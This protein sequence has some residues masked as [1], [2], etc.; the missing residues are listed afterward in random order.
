MLVHFSTCSCQGRPKDKNT[1][2]DTWWFLFD[3]FICTRLSSVS[4][5]SHNQILAESFFSPFLLKLHWMFLDAYGAVGKWWHI[6]DVP[7]QRT[8]FYKHISNWLASGLWIGRS[9]FYLS[10]TTCQAN[11]AQTTKILLLCLPVHP[12]TVWPTSPYCPITTSTHHT[13][14]CQ[15]GSTRTKEHLSPTGLL[16]ACGLVD[17]PSTCLEP[18]AKPTVLKPPKYCNTLHGVAHGHLKRQ[19]SIWWGHTKELYQIAYATVWSFLLRSCRT[20]AGDSPWQTNHLHPGS[21]RHGIKFCFWLDVSL[22]YFINICCSPSHFNFLFIVSSRNMMSEA[23]RIARG[24]IH[25]LAKL[26]EHNFEAVI[27]PG[28]FGAAK[29]L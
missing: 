1:I 11:S 24:E 2:A 25:D 19:F 14:S 21:I 7:I 12:I 8:S 18:P 28:G 16:P 22:S 26:E 20:D 3:N 15:A 29:N 9:T 10:G 23:A 27:L 4:W 5:G 17:L 13:Q 6:N